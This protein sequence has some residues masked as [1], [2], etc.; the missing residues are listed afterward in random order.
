[1]RNEIRSRVKGGLLAAFPV[2]TATYDASFR[3]EL[4]KH[5]KPRTFAPMDIIMEQGEGSRYICF[6]TTGQVRAFH[7]ETDTIFKVLPKN[8]CFGELA[9]FLGTPRAA[10]IQTVSYFEM[11]VIYARS[12][13]KLLAKHPPAQDAT[14]HI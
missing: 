2:F 10:S 6:L 5:F 8:A 9:F 11:E 12:W 1:M 13:E 3:A 14:R 4:I 7:G